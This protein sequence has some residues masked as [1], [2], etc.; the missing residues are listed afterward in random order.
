[1]ASLDASVLSAEDRQKFVQALEDERDVWRTID[2]IVE[3]T[4]LPRTT[5]EDAVLKAR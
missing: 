3:D 4:G 1:M 5:V 2:G